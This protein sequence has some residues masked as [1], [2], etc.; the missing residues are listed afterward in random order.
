MVRNVLGSLIALI[1]A[2][3]AV[4]SPFRPWYDGR[5][6][7]DVRI[8][9]LFNGMTRNSAA[10]FG[11]L[12]LPLA[13]AALVTLI[14][15]ALCSRA[16]VALAGVIVLGFTILWMVRQGQAASEL[17][18]G[19]RGLG[20]GV[21]NA[22]GGGALLL[23][24]ALIM[25]GRTRR[26]R[27]PEYDRGYDHRY[28]D[29]RYGE[30]QYD[31]HGYGRY[32]P[33]DR[34]DERRPPPPTAAYPPA[35]YPPETPMPWDAGRAGAEEWDSEPYA[36]GPAG[37]RTGAH[38]GPYGE[39]D[40]RTP[41]TPLPVTPPPPEGQHRPQPPQ[42]PAPQPPPPQQPQQDRPR[43]PEPPPTMT[44]RRPPPTPPV[45]WGRE[46]R[47]AGPPAPPP[48]PQQQQQQQQQA[49]QE[50][51]TPPQPQQPQRPPED[52]E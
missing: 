36:P 7:R 18:A 50:A 24:G 35:A 20:V 12:L 5:L 47:Q 25:R 29:A 43:A 22:L 31:D 41:T 26:F 23:L 52:R 15:V 46:Q 49:Q 1:G 4:W 16:L 40:D 10:L 21:A 11:S 9:D 42:S 37:P 38:P 45:E 2:T 13:F 33:D 39:Q 48:P 44:S 30:R 3:A 6:G 27:E 34:Y 17:T 19:A 28:D 32:A 51:D 14:G 8:E